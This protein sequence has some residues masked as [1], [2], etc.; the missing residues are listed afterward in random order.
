MMTPRLLRALDQLEELK[1]A[2][3]IAEEEKETYRNLYPQKQPMIAI[4]RLSD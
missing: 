4:R 1:K 2:I 3:R